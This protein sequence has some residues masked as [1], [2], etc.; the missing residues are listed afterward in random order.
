MVTNKVACTALVVLEILMGFAAVGGGLDLVLT[1]GQL[2][3][4]PAELLDGSPS[5]AS[6]SPGWCCWR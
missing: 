2:M 5:P 1:N 6:S 4:M 3:R